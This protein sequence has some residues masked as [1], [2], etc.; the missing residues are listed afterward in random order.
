MRSVDFGRT[1]L[2]V[3]VVGMGT[4]RTFDVRGA[5]AEARC[6]EIVDAALGAGVRVFDSSPMYGEAERVLGESL[7]AR[8]SDAIVAT[9]VWTSYAR[10]AHAQ[11]DRALAWYGGRVDI[12]QIHNLAAWR[13]HLPVLE[14][15]RDAGQVRVIGA[16]HYAHSAFPELLRAMETGRLGM[17]QIPYN[18]ADRAVERDVLPL[19]AELGLGV[20]VMRPFGE[21]TLLRRVPDD[22][23]LA[24]LRALGIET[25]PQALL[26][27]I[28]SEPRVHVP[29]PATSRAERMIE[30]ARASELP[31]LDADQRDYITRLA[32]G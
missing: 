31:T 25:W 4:W 7:G 24:P 16:T 11:I 3:P 29:I 15:L 20:L 8:R 32:R 13:A 2:R 10:E 27:W 9:K 22:S 28:L 6:R 5:A 14:A 1:G 18:A 17:I 23:A 21:G 26:A 19:A 12:Y 30:N